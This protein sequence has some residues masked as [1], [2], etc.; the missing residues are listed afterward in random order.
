MAGIR[1]NAGCSKTARDRDG[2]RHVDAD[3]AD[4]DVELKLPRDAAAAG[5]ARRSLIGRVRR[6]QRDAGT[7]PRPM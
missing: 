5:G 4:L 1:R 2:D 3:H 7:P 6:P